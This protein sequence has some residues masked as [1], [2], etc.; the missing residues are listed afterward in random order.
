MANGTDSNQQA[1]ATLKKACDAAFDTWPDCSHAVWH[2]LKVSVS[3]GEPY[4]EAN[5]LID[6]L[7]TAWKPVNLEDAWQLPIKASS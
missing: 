7:S 1:T 6:H 5:Q 4:R 2:V 3:A